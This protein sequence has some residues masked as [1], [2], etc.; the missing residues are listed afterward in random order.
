MSLLPRCFKFPKMP[1]LHPPSRLKP[2]GESADIWVFVRY[3]GG[4][5][6]PAQ[7]AGRYQATHTILSF[8]LRKIK[9]NKSILLF[10]VNV[11]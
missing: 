1:F 8:F 3:Y 2:R 4:Y 11:K 9:N 6:A 10:T 7:S 5:K